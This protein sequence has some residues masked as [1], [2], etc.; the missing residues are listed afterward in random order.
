MTELLL[1]GAARE[2][3]FRTP[4]K[5][6]RLFGDTSLFEIFIKKLDKISKMDN[7]F[8]NIIVAVN[9]ND[10]TL[11]DISK[12]AK[13][14]QIVERDDESVTQKFIGI[15]KTQSYLKDFKEDYI[16]N[17]NACFPFLR[18][19]TI[20]Q[21]GEFFLE[22][23]DYIKSITCARERYNHFWKGDT[24]KPINNLDP[25]CLSTRL[26]PPILENVNHLLIYN[27]Q[28]MFD[29]DCYWDYTDNNPYIYIVPD[30]EEC[31]DIDTPLEFEICESIYTR[32]K[33]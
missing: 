5:M 33:N 2:N 22:R 23:S 26:L 27:R 4:K 7:P 14:I 18:P 11:W 21:F 32:K 29:H 15:A 3:S 1:V 8:S 10:K 9:R 12:K 17:V 20:I 16:L 13:Y 6:I 28:Y 31:L 30:N 24:H 25:T 19:E